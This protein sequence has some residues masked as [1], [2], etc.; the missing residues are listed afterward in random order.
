LCAVINDPVKQGKNDASDTGMCLEEE[1]A[2][3]LPNR[4]LVYE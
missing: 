1:K 4:E 2:V 3:I